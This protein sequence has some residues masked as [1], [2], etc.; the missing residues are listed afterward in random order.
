M[1]LFDFSTV[2]IG[3]LIQDRL[4]NSPITGAKL[5]RL[6][7][8]DQSNLNKLLQKK[9][10]DTGR[11]VKFSIA[12]R[13][14]FFMEYSHNTRYKNLKD[15]SFRIDENIHI[16]GIIK[17]VIQAKNL[18]YDELCDEWIKLDSSYVI[19]KSDIS[20]LVSRQSLDT[21]KLSRASEA[22]NVNFFEFYCMDAQERFAWVKHNILSKP[23]SNSINYYVSAFGLDAALTR[24]AKE[25]SDI[26]NQ[27][28]KAKSDLA[29]LEVKYRILQKRL[30]DAGLPWDVEDVQ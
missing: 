3:S 23:G 15:D 4:K 25:D 10:M 28:I 7:N 14:N 2:N 1:E 17:A 6:V 16:G 11:L 20:K 21:S 9:T 12:L 19:R 18:T 30:K 8:M 27:L 5:A 24:R 13:Y 29:V 22:L 26:L